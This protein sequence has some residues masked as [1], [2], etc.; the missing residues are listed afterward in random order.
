MRRQ[1]TEKFCASAKAAPGDLQ[2]DYFDLATVGLSLRVGETGHKSWMLRYSF[3]KNG[4]RKWMKLGTYPATSLALA[5][6][7]AGDARKALED[8]EGP[9]DPRTTLGA[10][11]TLQSICEDYI[12]RECGS[13]RSGAGRAQR[14]R[15][16]I[17]V[18]G[19]ADRHIAS[20]RRSDVV[21][22]LDGIAD[23]S[24]GTAAAHQALS[25]LSVVCNWYERRND[26]FT[27]PIRKGMSPHRPVARDRILSDDEIR[28]LW[29]KTADGSPFARMVRFLL[30]TGARRDE[31]RKAQRSE[32]DGADWTLPAARNKT[33]LD[34][35]RPLTP[36]ALAQ[37]G[38]SKPFAFSSDGGHSA[39]S[40]MDWPKAQ[41]DKA[42]GVTGW[43]LHDLRRT[44]RT[45]LSRAGV[46]SDVAEL[47]LGHVLKGVRSIYDRHEYR[48][49]KADALRKLA[50]LVDRIVQGKPTAV[51]LRRVASERIAQ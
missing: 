38:E 45:L 27:S 47:C 37:L 1:L 23:A 48:A 19:F 17:K 30:L 4:P 21:K 26:D 3:P 43:T 33:K 41:L 46:A 50:R 5:R 35:L 18:E 49:E 12:T 11:E 7:K 25:F 8:P 42:S 34:L 9:K 16:L 28:A 29:A 51:T 40:N 22:W 24:G 31:A 2:T 10:P 36:Q 44:A 14:M 15:R 6:Q 32:F 13:L 39:L 20:L